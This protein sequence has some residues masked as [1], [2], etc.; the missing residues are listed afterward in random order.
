MFGLGALIQVGMLIAGCWWCKEIFGRFRSDVVE[1]KSGDWTQRSVVLLIW[2]VT[3]VVLYLICSFVLH[4]AT[5]AYH[6][7]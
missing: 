2:A 7:W 5:N 1:I 6:A 4:V 3:G